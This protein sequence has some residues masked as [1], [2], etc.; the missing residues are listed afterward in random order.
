L[1]LIGLITPI[2]ESRARNRKLRFYAD[3]TLRYGFSQKSCKLQFVPSFDLVS[4]KKKQ[5]CII[6]TTK[7]SARH[8]GRSFVH[9][10]ASSDLYRRNQV[11][12]SGEAT[13][14][15]S[16]GPPIQ[17]LIWCRTLLN[18]TDRMMMQRG[19]RICHYYYY[20]YVN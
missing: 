2:P 19:R 7:K 18:S 15:Y 3:Y 10:K 14:C 1:Q 16:R 8:R 17:T 13:K 11:T 6:A 4:Q 5:I 20:Y 9:V 12:R